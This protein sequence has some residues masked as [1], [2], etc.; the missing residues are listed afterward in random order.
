MFANRDHSVRYNFPGHLAPNL[1]ITDTQPAKELHV[2]AALNDG[3]ASHDATGNFPTHVDLDKFIALQIPA[4][5]SFDQCAA[6]TNVTAAQIAL[7]RNMY[8]T[9]RSD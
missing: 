3:V 4:D 9:V 8:F 5:A 2:G 6:A 7:R 1:K